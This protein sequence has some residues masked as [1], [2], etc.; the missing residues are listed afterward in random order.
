MCVSPELKFSTR[1]CQKI[2]I[3]ITIAIENRSHINQ[4]LIFIFQ[5]YF[6][7]YFFIKP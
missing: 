3:A 4:T 1:P 2:S 7:F 5:P 6:D